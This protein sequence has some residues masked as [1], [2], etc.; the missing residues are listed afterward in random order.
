MTD[1]RWHNFLMIAARLDSTPALLTRAVEKPEVNGFKGLQRLGY[2]S[3]V[4]TSPCK[5]GIPHVA[6]QFFNLN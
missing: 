2:F 5:C 1:P 4:Y 3:Y 6:L